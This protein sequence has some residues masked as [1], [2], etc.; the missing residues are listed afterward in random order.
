[1][2]H[3][4]MIFAVV[5]VIGIEGT[6]YSEAW[7]QYVIES[8]IDGNFE[9]WEGETVV[10][11]TNG[12]VWIQTEYYY[13]YHYAYMPDVLIYQSHGVWKMIV[14]GIDK[15]VRVEQLR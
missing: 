4:A 3:L 15:A 8:K 14:D 10:K 12:Q 9:G 1:M 7:A 11:L 2:R 6:L 5:L 13:G